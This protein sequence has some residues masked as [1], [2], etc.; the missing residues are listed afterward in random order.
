MARIRSFS[1]G[2]SYAL[3]GLVHTG[4]LTQGSA[5]R[6][7]PGLNSCA[8]SRLLNLAAAFSIPGHR[9]FRYIRRSR[10]KQ[11]GQASSTL[12]PY[13]GGNRFSPSRGE[14]GQP[15]AVAC[16]DPPKMGTDSLFRLTVSCIPSMPAESE[17]G[18]SPPFSLG[19][20]AQPCA[21]PERIFELTNHAL[22]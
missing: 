12:R 21:V 14:F 11:F 18:V 22:A 16:P 9:L 3:S 8:A 10:K 13:D 4:P 2:C 19:E 1:K 6:L 15:W 20:F 7:H 17:N 5:L